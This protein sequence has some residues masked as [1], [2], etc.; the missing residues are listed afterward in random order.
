MTMLLKNKAY[1]YQSKLQKGKQLC[2]TQPSWFSYLSQHLDRK[3]TAFLHQKEAN[4]FPCTNTEKMHKS[5][6]PKLGQ[7]SHI[8]CKACQ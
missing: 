1:N 3:R 4:L 8:L 5:C 7:F 2:R 6:Y